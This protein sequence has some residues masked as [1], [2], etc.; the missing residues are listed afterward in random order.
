MWLRI[1][2][3]FRTFLQA[4][5]TAATCKHMHFSFFIY[6]D[7]EFKIHNYDNKDSDT[8]LLLSYLSYVRVLVWCS[9]SNY[10]N[11][12]MKCF[13]GHLEKRVEYQSKNHRSSINS[14][15]FPVAVFGMYHVHIFAF[16]FFFFYFNKRT[17]IHGIHGKHV[18]CWKVQHAWHY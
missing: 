10:G 2:A 14:L 8:L 15:T 17:Q 9:W 13:F 1:F 6:I 7:T 18:D 3:L 16:F 11:E 5:V 12:V 4:T